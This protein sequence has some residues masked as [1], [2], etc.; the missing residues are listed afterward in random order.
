MSHAL[1]CFHNLKKKLKMCQR[2]RPRLKIVPNKKKGKR[3]K[4]GKK[5]NRMKGLEARCHRQSENIGDGVMSCRFRSVKP[6]LLGNDSDETAL[7]WS[8]LQENVKCVCGADVLFSARKS[9]NSLPLLFGYTARNGPP[10]AASIP[11]G[12]CV[13]DLRLI[14]ASHG[15]T[16]TLTRTPGW[17]RQMLLLNYSTGLNGNL[18]ERAAEGEGAAGAVHCTCTHVEA[19]L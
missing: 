9:S 12:V 17:L 19:Q 6:P 8:S 2:I 15:D 14:G 13:C 3:R 7:D 18:Q 16:H 4:E 10:S 5:K 1:F 11:A